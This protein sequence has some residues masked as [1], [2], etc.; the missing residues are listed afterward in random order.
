M[1]H[2]NLNT[3][4]CIFFLNYNLRDYDNRLINSKVYNI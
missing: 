1:Y 2:I 4:C 3:V